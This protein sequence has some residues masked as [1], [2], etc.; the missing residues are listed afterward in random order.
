MHRKGGKG[1]WSSPCPSVQPWCPVTSNI[2][3][4]CSSPG[5][6]CLVLSSGNLAWQGSRLSSVWW[7]PLPCS[8]VTSGSCPSVGLPPPGMYPLVFVWYRYDPTQWHDLIHVHQVH[9]PTLTWGMGIIRILLMP[10]PLLLVGAPVGVSFVFGWG[11]YQWGCLS[12]I[13]SGQWYFCLRMLLMLFLLLL[14]LSSHLYLSPLLF[15]TFV[16][17][18]TVSIGFYTLSLPLSPLPVILP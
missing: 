4:V 9:I 11:W 8:G 18:C 13:F 3:Y 10:V 12:V 5:G 15:S 14:F 6:M 7:V 16:P 2:C 17:F 1:D